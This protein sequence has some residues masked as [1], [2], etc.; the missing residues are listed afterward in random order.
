MRKSQVLL[1]GTAVALLIVLLAF[2][3]T[4]PR[5]DKNAMPTVAPPMAGGGQDIKSISFEDLLASAK[6]KISAEKL[7]RLNS[8]EESV[9]RGDVKNQQ[10]AAYR[11]LYAAWDSLDQMPVA[12]HYLGEA[13]KLENS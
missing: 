3:R 9:V 10:I 1:V 5:P 4:V 2:G 11:A 13:A 8:L 7:L 6:S 12:A